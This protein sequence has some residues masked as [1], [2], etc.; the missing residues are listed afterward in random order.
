M[1][2]TSARAAKF[3]YGHPLDGDGKAE[4][5]IFD[6]R[7]HAFGALKIDGSSVNLTAAKPRKLCDAVKITGAERRR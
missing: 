5:L 6:R 3:G 7:N 2:T 4:C 1:K